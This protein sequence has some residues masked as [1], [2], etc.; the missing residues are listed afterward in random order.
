[1]AT[2]HVNADQFHAACGLA[3]LLCTLV[4]VWITRHD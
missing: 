4:A 2:P 1:M 3:A